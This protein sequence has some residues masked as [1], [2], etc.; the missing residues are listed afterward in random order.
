MVV[1]GDNLVSV[2]VSVSAWCVIV[3]ASINILPSPTAIYFLLLLTN[4]LIVSRFGYKCL[5]NA[6]MLALLM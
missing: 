1:Y 6:P 2:S 3:S 5:L 4:V